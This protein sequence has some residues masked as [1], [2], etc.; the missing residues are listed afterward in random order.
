MATTGKSSNISISEDNSFNLP[1]PPEKPQ[2]SD[3]CG[4]GCI[5]CVFDIYGEEMLKWRMECDKI[6]SGK[7]INNVV[8]LG[9]GDEVLSTS[10]FQSFALESIFRLTS[11]SCLYR[12]SIPGNRKL[13]LQ[14]GQH[15]I[16]R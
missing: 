6:K 12:F 4:T 15:L 3:C 1:E 7:A 11:N 10:E 9:D 8:Q 2:E 5:P 13:G 16:M 14:I